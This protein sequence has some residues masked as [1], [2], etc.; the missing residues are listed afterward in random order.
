MNTA[1]GTNTPGNNCKF[2]E[3]FSLC[4]SAVVY[5]AITSWHCCVWQLLKQVMKN[6]S[7]RLE[8]E[9]RGSLEWWHLC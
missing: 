6:M 1:I 9:N 8:A 5:T 3:Q 2:A 7:T 4:Q